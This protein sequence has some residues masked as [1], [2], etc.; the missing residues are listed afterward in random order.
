MRAADG[1]A[2]RACSCGAPMCLPRPR[3][4]LKPL[5]ERVIVLSF[6]HWFTSKFTIMPEER[7][8]QRFLSFCSTSITVASAARRRFFLPLFG[9]EGR[10]RRAGEG[11]C[12]QVYLMAEAAGGS[13]PPA[14][15]TR[16]R[17]KA[18]YASLVDTVACLHIFVSATGCRR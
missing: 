18:L 11:R 15:A 17:R 16:A 12:R 8:Q 7:C 1:H 5:T 14:S 2:G 13:P 10:C 3:R 4:R 6:R 9:I